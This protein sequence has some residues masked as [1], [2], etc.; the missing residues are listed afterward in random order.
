[1]AY[2]IDVGI[3]NVVATCRLPFKIDLEL[4]AKLFPKDVK[5]NP[6]YRGTGAPT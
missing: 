4:L 3:V 6:K 2:N 5:L 1:M